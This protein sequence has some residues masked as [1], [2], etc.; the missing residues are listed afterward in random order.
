MPDGKVDIEELKKIYPDAPWE[1]LAW[2][3]EHPELFP[4]KVKPPIPIGRRYKGYAIT[5]QEFQHLVSLGGTPAGIEAQLRQWMSRGYIDE[6]QAR[7]IW[8]GLDAELG[9]V[10]TERLRVE[11]EERV[12]IERKEERY[13]VAQRAG[14]L[15][16]RTPITRPAPFE[17]APA[18]E[19]MR[20]EFAEEMPKT[21]RWRDWFR[22]KYPR[23]VEQFEAKIPEAERREESWI[24]ILRKQK[25]RLREEWYALTPWERGE[26]P[27]AFAPRIQTVRF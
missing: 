18:L 20:G 9:R 1:T 5:R 14:V 4:F 19:E 27:T 25:P 16:E 8:A 7:D 11:E 22:S 26:R 23:L 15:F 3:A 12:G 6:F 24:E 2:L 21:E 17:Y 13:R 10:E